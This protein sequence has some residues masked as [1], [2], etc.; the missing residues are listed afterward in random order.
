MNRV[1]IAFLTKDRTEL[2]S[3]TIEPLLQPDK[4]DTWW[5][6][7]SATKEGTILPSN[8]Q[9]KKT[10]FNV[11]GGPDAAVVFALSTLLDHRDESGNTYSFIGLCENDVLLD[12]GWFEPTFDLFGWGVVD[13]LNVGAVSAR[14]YEDRILFQRDRYAIMHNLGWGMQIMTREAAQLALRHIRTSWTTENR[15]VFAQA[16]R[17]DIGKWW[18]FR[19]S[20]NMLC[21][22]WGNDRVLAAHGLASLALTPSPVQMIGQTPS[23]VEQGLTLVAESVGELRNDKAFVT[24]VERM[25]RV[26]SEWNLAFAADRYL[27]QT[28]GSTIYFAHQCKDLG[29]IYNG[30]WRLKWVQGF[31]PFGWQAVGVGTEIVDS[32]SAT[33]PVLGPC[34]FLVMGGSKGGEIKVEDLESGYECPVALRS[35]DG[36]ITSIAVPAGP[37]SYRNVRLTAMMPGPTFFGIRTAYQQPVDLKKASRFRHSDLPPVGN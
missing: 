34:S 22:D 25:H 9:I 10:H 31:G 28:D 5:F 36:H 23:L 21:A 33:I 16:S 37:G 35:D 29:A 24:F 13:G 15:R 1:A 7:G 19:A 26:H 30:A 4:F 8:Y 17:L 32:P 2:S 11:R 20:E 6:D 3:R 14:A 18:A 27:Q 12:P